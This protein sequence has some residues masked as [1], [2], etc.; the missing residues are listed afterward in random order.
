MKRIIKT[1]GTLDEPTMAPV[2]DCVFYDDVENQLYD[3]KIKI[4]REFQQE[5]N[6]MSSLSL[7]MA[8]VLMDNI[9]NYWGITKGGIIRNEK[10]DISDIDIDSLE[11]EYKK[12]LEQNKSLGLVRYTDYSEQLLGNIKLLRREKNLND[13]GI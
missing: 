9:V 7:E 3:V 10:I 2:I 12:Q 6:A 5:I 4:S 8:S 13:L 1:R 11:E